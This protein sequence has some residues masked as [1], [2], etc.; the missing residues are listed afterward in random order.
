MAIY[1]IDTFPY[2]EFAE[3]AIEKQLPGNPKQRT[4]RRKYM[5]IVT[6]FDIETTRLP[7]DDGGNEHSIM[8]VWMWQFGKNWTMLG[9]TWEEFE[10]AAVK[11]SGLVPDDVSLAV[12]VHNLSFEFQ[13]LRGVYDFDVSEVFALKKRK[14]LKASMYGEKLM[15]HCSYMHSNMSLN[16][17]TAK[18]QVEHGKLSG[19]EFDY[20]K[21]RYPWTHLS[22]RELDY[23]IN[24]VLGLVE[25]IMKEMEID[26]DTLASLPITSTGYVRRDAK[27]AM[28]TVSKSFISSQMPQYNTYRML[29]D[30]F[31]GGNTHANR[32]Y[33]NMILTNVYSDDQSSAY[34]AA[35]CNKLFPVSAFID[36][37]DLNLNSILH[38]MNDRKRA[39]LMEIGLYNLRLR[40]PMWGAPYLPTEKCRNIRKRGIN[41]PVIYDNGRIISA[42][43][44]EI[45]VTDIDFRIILDEY[46]F[47]D[48]EVI[49]MK[50]ARYG[51]LP[52]ELRLLTIAYFRSKTALKGRP[53][54]AIQ[55]VKSKNKLNSIYGMMATN[56]VRDIV[57]FIQNEFKTNDE[58][59]EGEQVSEQ[60]RLADA[61]S[62]AF[63]V[64]QWGVWV[65]AHCRMALE[66]G[67]KQA[68]YGFVYCDTDSVKHLGEVDYREY[69]GA[70][71]VECLE[72]GAFA[73]DAN[74]E[75]HYMG[76][77]ES[78]RPY[79]KF[80]TMGAKKYAVEYDDGEVEITVAGV[81]K[82]K[83]G[84]E[85][86]RHGGL[87]AFREGFQF[88][89]AGGTEAI[90]NDGKSYGTATIDGHALEIT[91][92][93]TLKPHPYTLGQTADYLRLIFFGK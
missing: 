80:I 76:V 64:Y 44:L 28:R 26:G 84:K 22:E 72:S 45:T 13:F 24:D 34:P 35:Q 3:I 77:Y 53:D 1:S 86:A 92:N 43:Y 6:A 73:E 38:Q 4:N 39:C 5:D 88:V 56:P 57:R 52:E 33:A 93:V 68:G 81:D 36:C 17:Y 78:E 74:G 63:L 14:V 21:K 65:T 31:R 71:I 12:F 18:M 83:G 91:S 29:R 79:K 90:Y 16:E 7:Q 82:R 37:K 69:N 49:S 19:D 51:K 62:K 11:I 85:L 41:E 10:H 42:G 30:A 15:L 50:T 46:D 9:R 40:N 66:D 23:C 55:Y 48:L 20:A 27:K 32:F 47:D 67:I 75:T 61:N 8:Y 60:K 58:M 2:D 70:R 59:P 89:E 25:C 54:D 87:I